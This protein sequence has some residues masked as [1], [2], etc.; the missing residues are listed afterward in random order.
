MYMH[1]N[2]HELSQLTTAYSGKL[3]GINMLCEKF[4]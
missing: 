4:Y 2:N 1:S 3:E